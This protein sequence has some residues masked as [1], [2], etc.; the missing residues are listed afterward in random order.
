[1]SIAKGVR[2]AG[3]FNSIG[4]NG[5]GFSIAVGGGTN[6]ICPTE[7]ECSITLVNLS[8]GQQATVDKGMV[9]NL[10]ENVITTGNGKCWRDTQGPGSTTHGIQSG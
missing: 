9:P 7:Y 10:E 5:V 6:V 2:T 1:M 8:R 3:L 4:R